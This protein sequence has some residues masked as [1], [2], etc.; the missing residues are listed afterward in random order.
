MADD[1]TPE[2]PVFESWG[3]WVAECGWTGC[4]NAK[5]VFP[6]QD[7]MVC[8]APPD[9]EGVCLRT[10]RLV[11]PKD[12]AQHAARRAGT[13]PSRSSDVVPGSPQD[14]QSEPVVKVLN[15]EGD[16]HKRGPDNDAL[17]ERSRQK[18]SKA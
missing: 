13:P 18:G 3:R 11:W 8:D 2:T 1:K 16:V 12:F 4:G 10:S 9:N 5:E 14:G 15:E 17:D 7:S 6:G